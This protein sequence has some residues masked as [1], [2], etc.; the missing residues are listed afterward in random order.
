MMVEFLSEEPWLLLLARPARCKKVFSIVL[1]SEQ[2][3]LLLRPFD[4][5]QRT[6][7]ISSRLALSEK[8]DISKAKV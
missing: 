3:K 6:N 8:G 2:T 7:C 1:M 5:C 4:P